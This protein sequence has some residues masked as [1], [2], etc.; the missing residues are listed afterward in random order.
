[1]KIQKENLSLYMAHRK[2]IEDYIF[3]NRKKNSKI[4]RILI[5]YKKKVL[6]KIK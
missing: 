5:N 3:E 2:K 4:L 6:K 1:M